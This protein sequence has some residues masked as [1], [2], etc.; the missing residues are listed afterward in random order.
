MQLIIDIE[1]DKLESPTKIWCVVCKDTDT[2]EYY[3]FRNLHE[4][5]TEVEKF[6][7]LVKRCTRLVG[8]NIL[9]YDY[10][11]LCNLIKFYDCISLTNI[12]DT[13]IISKLFNYSRQGHSIED[14]GIEFNLPKG[15]FNDWSKLSEEMVT[16][17]IR[18][19][20]ICQRIYLSYL[21]SI[22]NPKYRNAI[23]CEHKFQIIVNSLHNNGFYFDITKC[24]KLLEKVTLEL[25]N[26]DEEILK[27]FPPHLSLIREI[28]PER[29]KHGTLHR[30]DFRWVQEGDLSPNGLTYTIHLPEEYMEGLLLS[31]HG[32]I[33]WHTKNLIWPIF[34]TSWT[35]KGKSSYLAGKCAPAS[36]HI[37]INCSLE[38][39]QKEFSLEYLLTT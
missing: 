6:K 36:L 27:S 34:R 22:N 33:V 7:T 39:T 13:L 3:V 17:C 10:P 25:K 38:L 24:N 15:E 11:V 23:T 1:C 21:D 8:H 19:V 14:Y 20:D 30:K 12:I 26:L 9:G 5:Q 4:D 32:R 16:Y 28:H 18:D 2:G 31:V 29:T 35:L 37:R